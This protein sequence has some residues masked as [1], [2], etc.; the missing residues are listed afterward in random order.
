MADA[1]DRIESEVDSNEHVRHWIEFCRMSRRGL[2]GV[3]VPL[4]SNESEEDFEELEELVE[5][6]V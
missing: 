2:I 4:E 1:L 5:A 6:R 3:Q